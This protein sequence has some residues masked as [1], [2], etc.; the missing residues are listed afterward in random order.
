MGMYVNPSNESFISDVNSN[1]YVDKTG[2]K[3]YLIRI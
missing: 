3:K 1:I 2:L